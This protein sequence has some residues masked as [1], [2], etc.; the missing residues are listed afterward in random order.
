[1]KRRSVPHLLVLDIDNTLFDWLPYYSES[2]TALLA[3]LAEMIDVPY[4]LLLEEFKHLSA[5]HSKETSFVLQELP[6]LADRAAQVDCEEVYQR[7]SEVFLQK[8]TAAL[9]P[10]PGTV[11]TLATTKR[12]RPH[13]KIVALTDSPASEAVWKIAQLDLAPYFDGV[14]GL[15]KSPLVPSSA[16]LAEII[17]ACQQYRG[18]IKYMP[19]ACEKPS[20]R[21]LEM[22]MRDFGLNASE[23]DKVIYVGDN[24]KKDIALGKKAGVLTCWSEFGVPADNYSLSKTLALSPAI[25]I[26]QNVPDRADLRLCPDVTLSKFSDILNHLF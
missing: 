2:N 1:M 8:A 24:L 4:P 9:T 25:K 18:T 26:R 23:K 10:Y 20:T 17:T 12:Y 13:V 5:Q 19:S 6:S 16:V 7:C 15:D 11:V 14:Y 22:I 3:T 21:G